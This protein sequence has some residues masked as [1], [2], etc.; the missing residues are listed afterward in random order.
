[1]IHPL[2]LARSVLHTRPG[3]LARRLW[4]VCKRKVLQHT[5]RWLG[6]PIW[7]ASQAPPELAAD[8]PAP[9]F[10][11]RRHLVRAEG[12][13]LDI[14]LLNQ[15]H[16]L[17][18][19]MNWRPR[20]WSALAV[21]NLHYMEYLEGLDD[22][23]LV[24]LVEDWIAQN[25]PYQRGYWLDG[26][27]SYALSIRCVVWMQRI[28]ARSKRLPRR[29]VELA[30]RS[31]AIQLRFLERNLEADI[32]GNHLIKNIKALLWAGRF[33]NGAQ[34]QRWAALGQ[35]L[36]AKELRTQILADG[37]HYER[38]PA[39]H[40]QVFADLIECA[41]VVQPGAQREELLGTLHRM[42]QALADVTHP[43]G[44]VSLFNDG[45]LHTSYRPGECLE[46]YARLSGKEVIASQVIAL[47]AAGYYGVR[48][49]RSLVLI[50]CGAIAPDHLPAHG[51]GDVL[52]FEWSVQ[53][54]RMIVD[55]G[56]FEYNPGPWREFARSTRAHNTVTVGGAD[57]AE[58]W[59]AFRVGRRPRVARE[60]FE[61][62]GDVII[63][64]GSH[65][66]FARLSGAPR[67]RRRFTV[68]LGSLRVEDF[69][70]GGA[71]QEVCAR[72][73]CHPDARVTKQGSRVVISRAEVVLTLESP[74]A[75]TI[76]ESWWCPDF[77]VRL[78]TNQIVLRYGTAPCAGSF[79]MQAR[80]DPAAALA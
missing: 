59:S 37:L 71:G 74:F 63:V 4:L 48:H 9:L 26:W 18:T 78:K 29:F 22:L 62:R 24:R 36:L 49:D 21:L 57:Q 32:G 3:Q 35:R 33:F 55:A 39:Y 10:A 76:A 7:V 73:L 17:S 64:E 13:A 12:D 65:D 43:D 41:A 47:D 58:F 25:P 19:P 60:R 2:L 45:G 66:G 34:A 70:E 75:A 11:P 79:A 30:S 54:K 14:C 52:A 5:G 44:Y 46:A 56:V 31:L 15:R 69:V 27:N 67:H 6:T 1:M 20:N 77:G 68:G 50:D 16:A 51:H 72:L 40:T 8:L 61:I 80:S 23:V 38:S 28:A 42:A 53:G